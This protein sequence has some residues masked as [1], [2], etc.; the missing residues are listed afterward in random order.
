MLTYCLLGFSKLMIHTF[1]GDRTQLDKQNQSMLDLKF[2]S[3][4]SYFQLNTIKWSFIAAVYIFAVYQVDASTNQE[5]AE[6]H[7]M[8]EGQWICHSSIINWLICSCDQS[9]LDWRPQFWTFA[10]MEYLC[11]LIW[12]CCITLFL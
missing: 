10:V 6:I 1:E 8:Y 7:Y 2:W 12:F 11:S 3:V 5:K 9:C 4:R